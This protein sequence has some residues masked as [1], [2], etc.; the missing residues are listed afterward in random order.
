MIMQLFAKYFAAKFLAWKMQAES[1]AS[2]A[3]ALTLLRAA[4]AECEPYDLTLLDVEMPEMDGLTL[5]RAIKT[6][7]AI[8][9]TRFVFLT[10]FGKSIKPQAGGINVVL[11]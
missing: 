11:L 9:G 1:A 3:E 2:G 7:P 5:A 6:D 4:A 10:G 8:A